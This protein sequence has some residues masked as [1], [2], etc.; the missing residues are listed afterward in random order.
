MPFDCVNCLSIFIIM[1]LIV[2]F[3]QWINHGFDFQIASKV[4]ERGGGAKSPYVRMGLD[5]H[6]FTRKIIFYMIVLHDP[7]F[8]I[9][10]RQ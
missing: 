5:S 7:H 10:G 8:L 1:D 2:I 4:I 3:S 9:H 6:I